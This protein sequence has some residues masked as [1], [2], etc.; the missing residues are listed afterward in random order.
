[1]QHELLVVYATHLLS[2]DKVLFSESCAW[3]YSF[4]TPHV[5]CYV[6][7]ALSI[8]FALL[9]K[10]EDLSLMY[11]YY[12]EILLDPVSTIFKQVHF[13]LTFIFTTTRTLRCS[14]LYIWVLILFDGF[15]VVAC[16]C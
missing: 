1:M 15:P 12:H 8:L 11:K 7:N 5:F 10:V 13:L 14:F 4:F 2:D 6:I 16:Y 9:L 3:Q